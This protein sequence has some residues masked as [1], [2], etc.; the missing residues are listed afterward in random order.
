MFD[1]ILA[2]LNTV[3]TGVFLR[4]I[5]ES[6]AAFAFCVFVLIMCL[7][8]FHQIGLQLSSQ[9]LASALQQ[10]GEGLSFR[11]R[12]FLQRCFDSSRFASHQQKHECL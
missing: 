11:Y 3:E 8:S 6:G 4:V 5:G 1:A 12:D 2:R 7:P 10:F 9:A